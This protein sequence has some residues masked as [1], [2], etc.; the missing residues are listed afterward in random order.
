MELTLTRTVLNPQ[1]TLGR[2]SAA[3]KGQWFECDT[4]EPPDRQL[5]Q[6]MDASTVRRRKKKGLTAIPRGRYLLVVTHS[7][8]FKRWLP[9]LIGVK[10]F[11]GIRIHAGNT[12][13]D[14]AGCI[15]VG[16]AATP[17]CLSES[18]KTLQQLM[19][20]IRCAEQRGEQMWLTVQGDSPPKGE[21]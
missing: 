1:Y 6:D 21:E 3:V 10:G 15:L 12:V 19:N 16:Q 2:L 13:K 11:D 17:G 7:P 8:H 20:M 18:R 5:T 4:L 9:L 14:T